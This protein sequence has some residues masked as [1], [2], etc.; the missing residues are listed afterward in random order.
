MGDYSGKEKREDFKNSL[1]GKNVPVLT[2]DNKW[3][4]LLD[5]VGNEDVKQLEDE[6]NALL[7]RQG[8]MN[9]ETK[10]IKRIKK[11]LMDEMVILADEFRNTGDQET[12][13]K[14]E[15]KKR[16]VNECNE[17]LEQ[18]SEELL[19][20]PM[21]IERVNRE[22]ML[23]TMEHCYETMQENTDHINEISDWV[24]NIRVELK[25]NLVRKQELEAKNHQIYA[26]M[27]DLFGAEVVNLFDMR[28]NPE[29]Q[30]P[31]SRSE[32]EQK[33]NDQQ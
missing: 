28:Y 3:Y 4:R 1:V 10:D 6:L 19:D 32:A 25:K 31:V 22:L 33:K 11:S 20:V 21:E 13:K 26:Y 27:H 8:K 2:L 18:Y 30:H 29:E 14:L 12:G 16:L 15:E 7:K 17:K 24:D 9:T 23:V 5:R